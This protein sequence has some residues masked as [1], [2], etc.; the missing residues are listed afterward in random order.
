[1]PRKPT[2]TVPPAY[3]ISDRVR[4][5]ASKRAYQ[6]RQPGTPRAATAAHLHARPVRVA[7]VRRR[8]HG[9]GALR[10][11]GARAG[12]RAVRVRPGWCAEELQDRAARPR[13]HD[14][15]LA[16]GLAPTSVERPQFHLQMVYAV[17]SLTYA[18]FRR[19]LGRRHRWAV[20]P[21]PGSEEHARLK[22]RPFG[23][24]Q[25][26]AY[27]D[28]DEGCLS[29]GYFRA[30]ARP[31]GHTVPKG[32][33]F[34]A[35]SHDVIAHETT[36]ALLDALRSEFYFPSNPDVLAFHEGFADLVA[37]VPAL[38][39]PGGR[40][41]GFARGARPPHARGPAVVARAGVRPRDFEA[42]VG[43]RTAHRD[44]RRG[45]R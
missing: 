42:G 8:R 10:D 20:A 31:A 5:Q 6:P 28:R 23:L 1:M 34:T 35:L 38:Q 44:R 26:N 30:G 14:L 16:S 17:C 12:R 2:T 41:I 15:L 22:V 43:A 40:R 29:F 27:Y 24:R 33:I 3:E 18:A 25:K 9:P 4:W 21:A 36:H 39:S 7:P 13:R 11:A 19:A 45:P 37:L 32:M